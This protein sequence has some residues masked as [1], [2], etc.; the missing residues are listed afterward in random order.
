M[1]TAHLEVPGGRLLVVDEG[2]GPPIVLLHA[3]VADLRA[4]DAMVAP[5][6]AAGYRVVRFDARNFGDSSGEDVPFSNRADVIAVLDSL[7]IER[8]ALVGNSR[9]GMTAIDTA[10]EWPDRVVAVVGVGA[11]IG[12]FEGVPTPDEL[13]IFEAYQ[14]VDSA[15]PFDADALT[16]FEGDVWLDGPGQ[17]AGRVPPEIRTAFVA[18]AGPLNAPGH[19]RVREVPLEP[20]ANDRLG[21][22]RCPVL[23]V[24]GELDF[25]DSVQAARRIEAA[26]PHGRA[27]VWPDVAHMI[28]ME[29]PQRLAATIVEFLAPLDRWA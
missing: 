8:A 18:M 5:L 3:A 16:Q 22:L 28:G 14:A 6:V 20:A 7:G 4:W 23:F 11:G 13:P 12:G 17:K 2:T 9:G 10:I 25:S 19:P 27:L 21:E 15:D 1:T 29:Q 26:A 24:A